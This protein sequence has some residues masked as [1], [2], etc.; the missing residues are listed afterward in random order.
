MPPIRLLRAHRHALEYITS[1][2]AAGADQ[3]R[4]TRTL[5]LEGLG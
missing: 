1:L 3:G 4:L 5:P 2:R